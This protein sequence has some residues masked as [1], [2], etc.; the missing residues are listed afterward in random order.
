MAEAMRAFDF[1]SNGR[2]PFHSA[3][4]K[5]ATALS[6]SGFSY[7]RRRSAE[8]VPGHIALASVPV[9]FGVLTTDTLEQTLES[10]EPDETNKGREAAFMRQ[11]RSGPLSQS[12]ATEPSKHPLREGAPVV[13][14]NVVW[15]EVTGQAP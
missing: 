7:V 13:T 1:V 5:Y 8:R 3:S 10:S 11:L 12:T 6:P 15:G 9:V 2:Q 4:L 14:L